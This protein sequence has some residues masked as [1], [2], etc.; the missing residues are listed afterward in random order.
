MLYATLYCIWYSLYG[1]QYFMKGLHI[2][3]L[4]CCEWN[5]VLM[6][7]NLAV[8]FIAIA[9]MYEVRLSP[10]EVSRFARNEAFA[11]MKRSVPYVSA[12]TLHSEKAWNWLQ[13]ISGFFSGGDRARGAKSTKWTDAHYLRKYICL[14][15]ILRNCL[16]YWIEDL[17][18]DYFDKRFDEC[19][20]F[21]YL[22]VSCHNVD[23]YT[24]DIS[25]ICI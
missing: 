17:S 15:I 11:N 3:W 10:H 16:R 7:R 1:H 21:M 12:D 19:L 9:F 23:I 13:S 8:A 5:I 18:L 25:P 14:F 2:W 24:V 6:L 22:C 4:F 20:I